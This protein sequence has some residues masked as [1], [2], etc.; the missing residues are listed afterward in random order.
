MPIEHLL[1]IPQSPTLNLQSQTQ[2]SMEVTNDSISRSIGDVAD[3]PP[4]TSSTS[5]IDVPEDPFIKWIT[6][7]TDADATDPTPVSSAPKIPRVPASIREKQDYEKYFVPKFVSIGPYHFCKNKPMLFEKRKPEFAMKLFSND[8]AAVKSLFDK[9]AEPEMVKDLRS[10]YDQEHMMASCLF[11]D[12]DFTKMMLLDGC[13]IFYF[14][15]SIYIGWIKDYS[16]FKSNEVFFIRRDLYLLENQIPFEVLKEVMTMMMMKPTRMFKYIINEGFFET[17][18]LLEFVKPFIDMSSFVIRKQPKRKWLD[19]FKIRRRST[20]NEDISD[21]FQREEKE[22]DHLLGALHGEH[23]RIVKVPTDS[24]RFNGCNFRSVNELVDVGIHFK[25]IIDTLSMTRIEFVK[26]SWWGFSAN[27]KLPPIAVSDYTRPMLLNMMAY[28][29]CKCSV[30]RS[31][32]K[33]YVY[34]LGTLIDDIEDVKI[35]RKAWVLHNLLASDQEVV[36]LFDEIGIDLVENGFKYLE[37]KYR[38]QR[39]LESWTNTLFSQL[40]NEYVKSPWAFLALLGAL[41]ALFLT[42]VQTYYTVWRP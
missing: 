27:V 17:S 15:C 11:S 16:E 4:G 25:P 18:S 32:V 14:I 7:S 28:E 6:S 9:L 3:A 23:A 22:P 39:H 31:W 2:S 34:L 42:G 37:V 8:R 19:R 1:I 13:F 41:I 29:T 24:Y 30:G 20:T 36:K 5:I 21:E 35:L 10:Y 33:S 38:I 12:S 40:K 26:G